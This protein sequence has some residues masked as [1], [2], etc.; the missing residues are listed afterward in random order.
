M[1]LDL[2]TILPQLLPAAIAWAEVTSQEAAG[3]GVAL[4]EA[5]STLAGTVGVKHPNKVRIALVDRLPLPSDPTLREAAL[6][7][8]L[9]GPGMVGLTLGYSILIC[10]G[11]VT[12][13]L[14]SHEFRHV[15]QYEQYGSIAE[16]LPVYLG[17]VVEYGYSDAPFECDA[18]AHEQRDI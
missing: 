8:G 9:L 6:Q 2:R 17:Q 13:R 11:H 14:L 16:F 12:P 15:A 1:I 3:A 4:D 18:Q 5:N 7:T 10:N